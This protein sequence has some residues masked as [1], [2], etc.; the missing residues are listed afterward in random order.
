MRFDCAFDCVSRHARRFK[1][2]AA[3]NVLVRQKDKLVSLW[4]WTFVRSYTRAI[5]APLTGNLQIMLVKK[6]EEALTA[7]LKEFMY[8]EG[9]N[10]P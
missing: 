10:C 3:K 1:G 2:L 7:L 5:K 8:L 4:G 9:S 6:A